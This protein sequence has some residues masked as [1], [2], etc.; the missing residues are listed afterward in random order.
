MFYYSHYP[1]YHVDGI[2]SYLLQKKIFNVSKMAVTSKTATTM[3]CLSNYF[4]LQFLNQL[5]KNIDK[6][7]T[8]GTIFKPS[9]YQT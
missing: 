9:N 8:F 7:S 4:P 2:Y 6:L 3:Y 5:S 1:S